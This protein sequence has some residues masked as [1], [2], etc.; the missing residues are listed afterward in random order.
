MRTR[1]IPPW[2]TRPNRFPGPRSTWS[3]TPSFHSVNGAT[4]GVQVGDWRRCDADWAVTPFSTRRKLLAASI[5]WLSEDS[6]PS[7]VSS[8]SWLPSSVTWSSSTPSPSPSDVSESPPSYPSATHSSRSV[9][10]KT[11]CIFGTI[12]QLDDFFH[13]KAKTKLIV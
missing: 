4:G 6:A 12:R 8:S 7:S 1:S 9:V 2:T 5:S 11:L 10:V 3:R 13:L